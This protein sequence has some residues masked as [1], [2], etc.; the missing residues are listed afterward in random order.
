[1]ASRGP[2]PG[3]RP[4]RP[5]PRMGR[6]GLMPGGTRLT[7]A[8]GGGWKV[9]VS[10]GREGTCGEVE[11]V[12]TRADHGVWLRMWTPARP[13]GRPEPRVN[14]PR[15]DGR[16]PGA[17]MC[18]RPRSGGFPGGGGRDVLIAH[19]VG[20]PAG[21]L[22]GT[23]Y[24]GMPSP[25]SEAE[26]G[27]AGISRSRRR[28]GIPGRSPQTRPTSREIGGSMSLGKAVAGGAR[29]SRA[30]GPGVLTLTLDWSG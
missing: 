30:R 4:R 8:A 23:K 16:R 25:R 22:P 29:K 14:G 7:F 3:S 12:L 15:A 11:A 18:D 24:R 6:P 21:H 26:R 17:G 20:N 10:T 5:R 27:P 28:S 13:G 9:L 2:A 19:A 1:M